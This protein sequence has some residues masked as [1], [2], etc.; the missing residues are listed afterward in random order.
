MCVYRQFLR[1][2]VPQGVDGEFAA[3]SDGKVFTM[4]NVSGNGEC[5]FACVLLGID[6]IRQ[7]VTNPAR[8]LRNAQ[9]KQQGKKEL[10]T[11]T[12]GALLAMRIYLWKA[13]KDIDTYQYSGQRVSDEEIVLCIASGPVSSTHRKTLLMSSL[14]RSA[15]S[16]S[17]L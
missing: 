12:I 10:C 16:R 14:F 5:L 13:G 6:D 11:F 1:R 8:Q 3:L 15:I 2:V 17:L 9:E 4:D 7:G